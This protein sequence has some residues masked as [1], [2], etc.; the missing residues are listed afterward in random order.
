MIRKAQIENTEIRMREEILQNRIRWILS[1]FLFLIIELRKQRLGSPILKAKI[2]N[3]EIRMREDISQNQQ[4]WPLSPFFFSSFF[5]R[6]PFFL[7][8]L[9]ELRKQRHGSPISSRKP[10]V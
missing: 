4:R 7:S 5:P 1:F 9:A 6:F 8:L 2:E 3:N 10:I